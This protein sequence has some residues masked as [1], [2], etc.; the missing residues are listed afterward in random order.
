MNCSSASDAPPF[1][2]CSAN[3]NNNYYVLHNLDLFIYVNDHRINNYY[4]FPWPQRERVLACDE[5]VTGLAS[6]G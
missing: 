2:V 1:C 5:R 4:P 6:R 3:I